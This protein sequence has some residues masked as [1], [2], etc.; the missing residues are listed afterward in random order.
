MKEHNTTSEDDKGLK[1]EESSLKISI[2]KIDKQGIVEVKFSEVMFD[3]LIGFVLNR[4][5]NES[6]SVQVI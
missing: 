3:E 6:L 2:N 5:N 1:C 4:I